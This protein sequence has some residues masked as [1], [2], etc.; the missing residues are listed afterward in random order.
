MGGKWR[1]T[2]EMLGVVRGRASA[3]AVRSRRRLTAALAAPVVLVVI[4]ACVVLARAGDGGPAAVR[5]ATQPGS[6]GSVTTRVS[7]TTTLAVPPTST[8]DGPT[9][10]L[11]PL[12]LF[13]STSSSTT[14]PT[15]APVVPPTT[16]TTV[17]PACPSG[18]LEWSMA[19]DKP[20]YYVGDRVRL[21]V[22]VVNRSGHTCAG[23]ALVG[24]ALSIKSAAGEDLGTNGVHVDCVG[25][26]I[27]CG[28]VLSD[29]QSTSAA[30]CWDQHTLVDRKQV[31]PGTY[32]AFAG[33]GGLSARFTIVAAQPTSTT[34]LLQYFCP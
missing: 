21:V 1:S 30:S 3:M 26:G 32:Q 6:T 22:T 8:V 28:P 16:T 5:V 29:G 10:S 4:A 25:P 9:V 33:A 2:E 27:P 23:P 34:T 13:P 18:S 20:T 15:T 17:V 14:P 19:S 11:F 24:G 12:P 31:P 7:P